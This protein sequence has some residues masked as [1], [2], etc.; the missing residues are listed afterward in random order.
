[1]AQLDQRTQELTASR[2]RII[3]AGDTERER[4][5]SALGREVLPAMRSLRL[6]LE[7]AARG[8]AAAEEI[9][10]FG[11]RATAALESLRE[12]T[13]GIFPTMLPRSGL[14]PALASYVARMEQ[15]DVLRIDDEVMGSRYA[16]RVEAAAYFC[17]VEALTHAT[18]DLDIG[19]RQEGTD[20]VLRMHGVD[21]DGMDRLAVLDRVEACGGR[22]EV[23]AMHGQAA[24][25]ITL[26]TVGVSAPASGA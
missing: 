23:A 25:R 22:L 1:M 11:D 8:A 3:G 5:E 14:G 26:P 20:L 12:L 6:A 7:E 15:Q 4:L 21:L 13:R 16:D 18:G 19:V 10:A 17:C 24:L 2:N 9:A